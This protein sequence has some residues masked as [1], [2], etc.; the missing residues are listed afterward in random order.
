MAGID[1]VRIL[2]GRGIMIAMNH[3]LVNTVINRCTMP[4]DGDIIVP[5]RTVSVI[6]TTDVH[7]EDPDDHTVHQ[8]EVDAMLDEGERLVPGF[9]Q[10]RA[11][12]VWTGVRPLFEDAKA[13]DTDSRDVT[14]SHALLDHAQRDGVERFVTMTGGK[15]TTYRL[16]AQDTV[17]DVCRLLGERAACTTATGRLPGS[18]NQRLY[19]HHDGPEHVRVLRQAGLGQRGHHAA[20]CGADDMHDDF[21][22]D[23]HITSEPIVFVPGLSAVVDQDVGAHPS[24]IPHAIGMGVGHALQGA[25]GQHVHGR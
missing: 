14:R 20:R 5:I 22:A 21:V 7:A 25:G 23:V 19:D 24:R 6:G 11:L 13:A 9:R 12:R 3:R 8:N 15:L 2:P 4:S 1:G 18:D 16:M 10:A 17:D